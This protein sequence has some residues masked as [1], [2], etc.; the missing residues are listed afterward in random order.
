MQSKIK[1]KIS[2]PKESTDL[3]VKTPAYNPK[4]GETDPW[5]EQSKRFLPC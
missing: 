4:S 5:T 1:I 2:D 3:F